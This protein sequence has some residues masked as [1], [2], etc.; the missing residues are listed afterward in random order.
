MTVPLWLVW[1]LAIVFGIPIGLFI[2][3]C[4]VVGFIIVLDHMIGFR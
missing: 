3:L 4:L 2:L 1:T